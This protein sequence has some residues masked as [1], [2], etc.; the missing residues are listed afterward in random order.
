MPLLCAERTILLKEIGVSGVG[1]NAP[2]AGDAKKV[3]TD[4]GSTKAKREGD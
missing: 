3:S 2:K 4:N 1:I